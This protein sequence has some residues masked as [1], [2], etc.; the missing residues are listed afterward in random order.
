MI[1]QNIK[2]YTDALNFWGSESSDC[3]AGD[4]VDT[5]VEVIRQ[6]RRRATQVTAFSEVHTGEPR[7]EPTADVVRQPRPLTIFDAVRESQEGMSHA[8]DK[9]CEKY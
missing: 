3:T 7:G 8:L 5:P 1:R 6:P 9:M 2:T 4:E